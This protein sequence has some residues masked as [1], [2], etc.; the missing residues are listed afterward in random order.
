MKVSIKTHLHAPDQL[1]LDTGHGLYYWSLVVKAGGKHAP[2]YVT[3]LDG[4]IGSKTRK[5]A[6]RAMRLA[7]QAVRF[8]FRKDTSGRPRHGVTVTARYLQLWWREWYR[9]KASRE[10]KKR[11]RTR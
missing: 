3:T 4:Y 8:Q 10:T 11:A 1:P 5:G 2:R 7:D 9:A 6:L